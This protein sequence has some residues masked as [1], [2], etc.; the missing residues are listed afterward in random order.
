MEFTYK[1][2]CR[3]LDKLEL[4]N[5]TFSSYHN[6]K[7]HNKCVI[8]RHDIDYEPRKALEMALLEQERGVSSTFFILV[9]SDFYNAFSARN[10]VIIR[11]IL[12]CGHEIGLHFDEVRYKGIT[13]GEIRKKIINEASLLEQIIEQPV[14][15][16]S[17]HRPSKAMLESNL[18]IPGIVNS[19]GNDYYRG[20]KY[21]SDSRRHWREPVEEI[22]ESGQYDRLHI[23]THA[24]WYGEEEISIHDAVKG[25][26]NHANLERYNTISDNISFVESIMTEEEV[27]YEDH[28]H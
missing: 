12:K 16:V 2:Y 9:T 1:S 25:F 19:Y 27:L 8:L 15:T 13:V 23:L 18:F 28:N 11:S 22:I 4:N 7:E 21:L 26:V 20:F 3:L 17:M 24:F 6:W 5:Y 10:S 14:K